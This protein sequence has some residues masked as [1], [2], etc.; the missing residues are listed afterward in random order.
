MGHILLW[1]LLI[2][3][4]EAVKYPFRKQCVGGEIVESINQSCDHRRNGDCL[5]S[6]NS[7]ALA[8]ASN[9]VRYHRI[10]RRRR[11]QRN[12][13]V[14][15]APSRHGFRGKGRIVA[16]PTFFC[17]KTCGLGRP[18]PSCPSCLEKEDRH[19][20]C[21]S[22]VPFF[23]TSSSYVFCKDDDGDGDGD[24]DGCGEATCKST[25]IMKQENHP[26]V[27]VPRHYRSRAI[28]DL[29][30]TLNSVLSKY[31]VGGGPVND[32]ILSLPR[33]EREA[34]AVSR[35]L[36]ERLRR[37]ANTGVFC[38]SCW[39]QRAHCVCDRLVPLITSSDE[40]YRLRQPLSVPFPVRTLFVLM[41]HKEAMLAVD[42]AKVMLSTFPDARLVVG[43]IGTEYQ[44]NMDQMLRSLES[45]RA[46]VLFPGDSATEYAEMM[47][48]KIKTWSKRERADD[49]DN[50]DV[51]FSVSSLLPIDLIVIDGTWSQARRLY[52][53]LPAK[54][55]AS[56]LKLSDCAIRLVG[57]STCVAAADKTGE[58]SRSSFYKASTTTGGGDGRQM[59]RHDI[60][61]REIST[62]EAVR[63]LLKDMGNYHMNKALE[64]CSGSFSNAMADQEQYC[65]AYE[66]W[67]QRLTQYQLYSDEAAKRQLG[68]PRLRQ[69]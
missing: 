62:L 42:T 55:K 66:D 41:H 23:S 34:V 13:G 22:I 10:R 43:G 9:N 40:K 59:R 37:A 45:G 6:S 46:M 16:V 17:I 33:T 14:L 53:S 36:H 28:D 29:E 31:G 49:D 27:T 58:D 50:C 7:T 52:A 2:T 44:K 25:P 39:L 69:K 48:Q 61:W 30:E 64:K 4:I 67:M 68:P 26:A 60:R 35:R 38:R 15:S 51:H 12:H 19:L 65:A 18:P 47:A 24:G 11:R 3:T 54:A 63:L 20:T 1:L 21:K 5:S 57:N 8:S 56:C 32:N